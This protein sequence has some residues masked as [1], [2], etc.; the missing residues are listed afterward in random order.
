MASFYK[1]D[2]AWRAQVRCKGVSKS[3]SGFKTK[4]AAQEWAAI[5]EHEI[6][7]S[8]SSDIPDRPFGDA[9]RK[10]LVQASPAKGG[11]EFE[12]RRLLRWLGESNVSADEICFVPLSQLKPR[13][14]ADWRD[15]RLEQVSI[16][17]VLR[18]WTL[19]SVVISYCI[20]EWGW[21]TSNPLSSVKRPKS[22]EPRKRRP[23]ADEILMLIESTGC[24]NSALTAPKMH[25]VG[26]AITFAIETAMRA[27]EICGMTW[28]N[29]NIERRTVL[30]P[31]TKNGTSRV[32][33]LSLVAIKVLNELHAVTANRPTCFDVSS[34]TLDV[35]FRRC[36]DRCEIKDLHF[37][38]FRRE[39]LT[40]MA[41]KIDVMTLAKISGHKDLK[42][43]QSVYFAPDIA[44]M[45]LD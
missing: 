44:D 28:E 11:H 5:V 3:Q 26:L 7:E 42:I 21:L 18:E 36:R 4:R 40:R 20:K 12:R 39:A 32:V 14:F 41:G 19:L 34:S 25:R 37:H 38:D 13:H 2:G 17:T 31:K 30:L 8:L 16:G 15:R 9:L 33:P 35:L 22:P 45:L 10:Y 6:E 24:N 1:R 27:G 29:V 23:T 43:L